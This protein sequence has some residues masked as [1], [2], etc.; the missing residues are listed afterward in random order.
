MGRL[1]KS[2]YNKQALRRRGVRDQETA[3]L[4]NATDGA[5]SLLLEWPFRVGINN[6]F[7]L[8]LLLKPTR[9]RGF[10]GTVTA[11]HGCVAHN[12]AP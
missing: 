3:I 7:G 8:P 10:P 4:Y 2:G 12:L 1:E 9:R 6:C 5:H 11:G